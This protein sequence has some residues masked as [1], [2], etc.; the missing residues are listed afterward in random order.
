MGVGSSRK[1][2]DKEE[3][4]SY[5]LILEAKPERPTQ[6]G[7]VK[8]LALMSEAGGKPVQ[9]MLLAFSSDHGELSSPQRRNR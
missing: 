7:K 8:L 1:K 2:T 6:E 4:D 3:D 9:N 5:T